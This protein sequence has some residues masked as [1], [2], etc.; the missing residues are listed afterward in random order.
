MSETK[1]KRERAFL[2]SYDYENGT[3][4]VKDAASGNPVVEF[5]LSTFPPSVVQKLALSG[6]MT[7]VAGAGTEANRDGEDGV[8]AM[9]EVLSDLSEDKLEFTQGAGVAMGG[10]IK[11]VA[12]A[13]VELGFSHLKAPNGDVLTWTKGDINS[14]YATLRQLWDMPAGEGYESGKA[15]FNRIK[16]NPDVQAKLLSYQKKAVETGLG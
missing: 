3:G 4:A 13:V 2:R 10:A 16:A 8:A 1:I 11:R 15:R 6:L 9:N 7:L 14:A 5:D 12:R